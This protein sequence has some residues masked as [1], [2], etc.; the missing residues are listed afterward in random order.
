M[1]LRPKSEEAAPEP[2][3]PEQPAESQP[4]EEVAKVRYLSSI[5]SLF[6]IA[7]IKPACRPELTPVSMGLCHWS[8]RDSTLRITNNVACLAC[9]LFVRYLVLICG[10]Y[11]LYI[12]RM[13]SPK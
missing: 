13:L 7:V 9:S 12:C 8:E 6:I 11:S 5:I 4:A 2:E 3:K 1:A 10:I